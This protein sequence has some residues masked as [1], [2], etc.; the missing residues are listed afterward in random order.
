MATTLKQRSVFDP[1]SI[2]GLQL[3]LDAADSSTVVL[4]GTSVIQWKDKSG[5]STHMSQATTSNAPNYTS[6]NSKY[7]IDFVRANKTYLINTTLSKNF[8][9][10]SLF[11]IMKRKSNSPLD[12]ERIF[13]AIPSGYAT[14][15]NTTTGFSFSTFIEIASNGGG[16]TYYDYYNTDPVLY[17]LVSSNNN[18]GAYKNGNTAADLTRSLGINGNSIGILLGSGTNGAINTASEIFNGYIGEILLYNGALTTSQKQQVEGYLAWKWSLTTNLPTIHPF[19]NGLAPFSY[20]IVPVKAKK[21]AFISPFD[22]RSISGCALWLD[23]ADST[24]LTLS[25]SNVTQWKD[26]STNLY[27]ASATTSTFTSSNTVSVGG[28]AMTISNYVWRTKFTSF[29]VSKGGLF[30]IIDARPSVNGLIYIFSG[31]W[32]LQVVYSPGGGAIEL[33]DSVLAQGTSVV[34]TANLSILTSGYTNSTTISPYAVNGTVRTSTRTAGTTATDSTITQTLRISGGEIAE[35]ILYNSALTTAQQQQVEAYLAW[36]WGLQTKLPSSH[37]YVLVPQNTFGLTAPFKVKFLRPAQ[38]VIKTFLYT[39]A[40]QT[41]P[42][43]S[44]VTSMTVYLWGAGGGGGYIVSGVGYTPG[45]GGAGAMVQG[46]LSVTGGSTLYIVVGKAGVF[47]EINNQADATG[48]GGMGYYDGTV[49]G[50]TGGGAT[51]WGAGSGGGRSAIQF[52]S[53]GADQVVAGGGGGGGVVNTGSAN[54]GAATFSGTANG[55]SFAGGGS[56]LAGGAAGNGNGG[57]GSQKLGGAGWLRITSFGGG[58][59]GGG[60]YGGG[61][62][63]NANAYTPGGAGSSYTGNLTALSGQPLGYNSANGI[64]APNT[65]SVYYTSGIGEGGSAS[66]TAGTPGTS[67]SGGNGFVV[68]VYTA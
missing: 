65:S 27:I 20:P 46:T 38:Q 14:D 42:V 24:T 8:S 48:G 40:V 51:G 21:T 44:G 30:V 2:S 31:N 68:L 39:G 67:F 15:W 11:I 35:I 50:Y 34:D 62:G 19:K 7:M 61:G 64:T 49:S 56:Q 33:G 26:K 22:P 55:S 5:T 18:A 47:A 41:L 29:I 28:S 63:G 43:P 58:G 3:W 13:V 10:F 57:A 53:G 17:S 59:G 52:S 6:V 37:P 12:N 36:K 23:G 9:T 1:K 16:T 4:S 54:G 45:A 25:G 66:S 60:Y 32:S